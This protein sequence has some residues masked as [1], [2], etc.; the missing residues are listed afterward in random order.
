MKKNGMTVTEV[1]KKPFNDA[2]QGVYDKL[3]YGELRDEV[4]KLLK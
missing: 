3:G 1:D 4:L 2:T